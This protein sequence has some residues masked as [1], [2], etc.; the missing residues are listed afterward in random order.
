MLGIIGFLLGVAYFLVGVKLGVEYYIDTGYAIRSI[1]F[2][3]F[4]IF[5]YAT[6]EDA[7]TEAKDRYMENNWRHHCC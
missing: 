2:G 1:L 7:L 6:Q 4:W 3:I 5:V